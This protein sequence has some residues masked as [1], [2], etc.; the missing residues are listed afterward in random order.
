MKY[1]TKIEKASSELK[2]EISQNEFFREE[3]KRCTK[4]LSS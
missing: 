2:M 3:I 4:E 1:T